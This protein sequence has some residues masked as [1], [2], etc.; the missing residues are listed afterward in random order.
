MQV[1]WAD[2]DDGVEVEEEESDQETGQPGAAEAT[3]RQAEAEGL[4]LQP[5]HNNATG[6]H[7]EHKDCRHG[8]RLTLAKPFY[9]Q[10]WRAG[11]RVYLDRFAT[12]EK[13]ALAYARMP[14]AQAQVAKPKPAPLTAREAVAQAATE[15]LTLEPSNG[16]AGYR[17]V[18]L[19]GSRYQA[20]VKRAGKLVHLRH[21]RGGG[22]GR[23]AS[24]RAHRPACR[25]AC[26]PACRPA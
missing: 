1:E 17:G 14:E 3:V 25:R 15:G 2:E 18:S 19:D 7:G 6:Y 4:T 26:R 5:S 23:H 10:V 9:A 12:A 8:L 11:E 13:A 20:Y 24:K 21:R 16:A 22:P